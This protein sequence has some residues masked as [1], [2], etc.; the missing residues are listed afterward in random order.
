MTI[1]YKLL[2]RIKLIL[3]NNYLLLPNLLKGDNMSKIYVIRCWLSN[4]L[5]FIINPLLR[6][7]QL[8]ILLLRTENL[9]L[10]IVQADGIEIKNPLQLSDI[11]YINLEHRQDRNKE[12]IQEF[13]RIGLDNFTRLN[14][15]KKTNGALG[16]AISHRTILKNW[17]A[18]NSRLLMVCEDDIV[19]N[20]SLKEL[21]ELVREF[22]ND[23]SL[24]I[25]CLS[26]NNFN[27]APYND[28]FN[29]TSDTQTT[30][31]YIVKPHM[32]KALIDNFSLSITMLEAGVDNQYK[33][34]IDKVW[35]LLQKKYNFVIPKKRFAYQRESFSDIE[36]RVVDYK[37]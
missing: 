4:N 1:F 28:Y 18:N 5:N 33:V 31:C 26:Y 37:V 15:F 8:K 30:G 27:E 20:C 22:S 29:L 32:K 14:A 36:N 23:K 6:K 7:L 2:R 35:K 21:E 19:F 16:C 10:A 9:K 25:L 13:N 17:T 24:D 12:V 34:A 3:R 11:Y